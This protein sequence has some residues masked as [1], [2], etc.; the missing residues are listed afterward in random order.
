MD[1][2]REDSFDLMI[3][4]EVAARGLDIDDVPFIINYDI[5]VDPNLYVHR[6][7]RTARM[8]SFGRAITL[9]TREQGKELTEVEQRY[10]D[11]GLTERVEVL[12]FI[13]DMASAYRRA[14]AVVARAGATT[15]T[16]LALCRKPS[17][18]IPF[19]YAADNHQE[20][21][22]RSLVEAGAA[23]THVKPGD[24]VVLESNSFCGDCDGCRNGRVDLCRNAPKFAAEPVSVSMVQLLPSLQAVGQ[25]EIGSQVSP[26]SMTP[27]SLSCSPRPPRTKTR[28]A[29]WRASSF[30]G[31]I[32]SC[33]SGS[34][35]AAWRNRRRKPCIAP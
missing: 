10:A 22:A 15:V 16:E 32:S 14:D 26:G 6:I 20:V 13:D 7:G 24:Q 1:S 3:A 31:R 23:V 17:I 2:F 30:S 21:N 19:P 28:F 11:K 9:V 25:L 5:P 33:R 29:A 8:G 35:T 12:S 4:T 18:L 34:P 27:L